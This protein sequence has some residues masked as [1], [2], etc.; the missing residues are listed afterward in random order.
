MIAAFG[1]PQSILLHLVSLRQ[2]VRRNR[3]ATR[4]AE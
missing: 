4:K 1:V 2:L 3:A